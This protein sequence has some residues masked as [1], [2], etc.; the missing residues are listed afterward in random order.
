MQKPTRFGTIE[1]ARRIW[2]VGSIHG[3]H[4]R[5]VAVHD[6]I[7]RSF[8][9]GD[10]LVYLGNYLGMGTEVTKTL[11]ELLS[12]RRYMMARHWLMPQDLQYLRG[13]QEEMW[14]RML[15]LHFSRSP[16]SV[17]E[18]MLERGL[19]QT[20]EAY[21]S[22]AGEARSFAKQKAS[23]IAHYTVG[24]RGAMRN[25]A[26]HYALMLSLKRAV[27]TD[28]E[29]YMFVHAGVDPSMAP[30]EQRDAFWWG[31][32]DFR[33]MTTPYEGCRRVLAGWHPNHIGIS[34]S[35]YVG[36]VDGGAGFGGPLLTA[37]MESDGSISQAYE[38]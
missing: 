10:R 1:K 6:A 33:N 17:L 32:P 26:G 25:K 27:F 37:C 15:Q 29:R 16:Q 19:S 14:D 2:L 5:L 3:E 35:P 12:F 36:F 21:G 28:D 11:D 7:A 4:A 22:S 13:A 20:L 9:A 34:L 18:W 38:A 24:L 30:D 31:H 23:D 8:E